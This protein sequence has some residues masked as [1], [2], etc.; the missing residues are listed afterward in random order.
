MNTKVITEEMVKNAIIRWLSRN[1]WGTNLKFGCL[2]ERGVDIKV[3][4]NKYARYFLIETKG[5][6]SI[7]S[8]SRNAQKETHFVFGLG[9]IV[10]R[11]NCGGSTRYYYGLGLPE[12]SAK[13]ALRRLPWQVAKKLLLF[14]FAV[15]EKG[16]VNQYSWKELKKVQ[17][18]NK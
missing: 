15:D 6:G 17:E 2:R 4:H 18:K 11:M 8:K 1:G 14:V 12:S 5:E 10:T 13:I 7:N 9:Q 3:R 16:D